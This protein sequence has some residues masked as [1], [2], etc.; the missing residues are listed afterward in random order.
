MFSAFMSAAMVVNVFVIMPYNV[1]VNEDDNRT[2]TLKNIKIN[3]IANVLYK[4][5]RISNEIR[6]ILFEFKKSFKM[7]S[8]FP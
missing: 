2:Y 1:F 5:G 8:R 3:Y 7:I 6:P 4:I